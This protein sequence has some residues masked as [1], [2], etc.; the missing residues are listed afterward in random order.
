MN[1][2]VPLRVDI[3]TGASDRLGQA[4]LIENLRNFSRRKPLVSAT[5]AAVPLVLAALLFGYSSVSPPEAKWPVA[6]YIDEETG[7]QSLRRSDEVPPLQG[8]SGGFT[9]V[10]AVYLTPSTQDKRFIGYFEKCTEEAKARA[11]TARS[12]ETGI[13]SPNFTG[14]KGGILVRRPEKGS[15]W[16]NAE[17]PEGVRMLDQIYRPDPSATPMRLCPPINE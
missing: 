12:A 8:K 9:V 11:A 2:P 6:D 14:L 15:P 13:L 1:R 16:V 3:S 4:M 7:E 10:R 5:L 17:S